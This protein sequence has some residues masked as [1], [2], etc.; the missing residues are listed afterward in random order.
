MNNL[1]LFADMNNSNATPINIISLVQSVHSSAPIK[2][3][4]FIVDTDFASNFYWHHL[5]QMADC[6]RGGRRALRDD[7]PCL[8]RH[9]I[10]FITLMAFICRYQKPPL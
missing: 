5:T 9:A 2:E 7:D 3:Q 6:L 4:A 8:S 10:Q 1:Y